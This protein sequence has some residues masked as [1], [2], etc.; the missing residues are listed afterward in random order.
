[1]VEVEEGVLRRNSD[2][3]FKTF[4]ASTRA[5]TYFSRMMG[6]KADF[7]VARKSEY[8]RHVTSQNKGEAYWLDYVLPA[9]L[10][11]DGRL[12]LVT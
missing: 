2:G 11:T 12:L 1:M 8:E 4:T 7:I 5:Y 10:S 9:R 6:H 3:S